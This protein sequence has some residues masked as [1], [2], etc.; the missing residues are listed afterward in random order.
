MGTEEHDDVG[1]GETEEGAVGGSDSVVSSR[2]L[3]E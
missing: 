2:R 3:A 1:R